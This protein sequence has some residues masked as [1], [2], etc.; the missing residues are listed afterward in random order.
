MTT[1]Q[2]QRADCRDQR[3]TKRSG[4]LALNAVS[5]DFRPGETIVVQA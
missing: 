5:V 1:L 4:V 3:V 2:D